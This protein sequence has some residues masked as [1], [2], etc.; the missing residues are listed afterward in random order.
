[1]RDTVCSTAEYSLNWQ[2]QAEGK[3]KS[4]ACPEVVLGCGMKKELFLDQCVE[5]TAYS[6]NEL[7]ENN[8]LPAE[9]ELGQLP[10]GQ[11]RLLTISAM[12]FLNE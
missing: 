3:K 9:S 5:V 10:R 7:L 12:E 1:M 11:S 4:L 6:F 2:P 8:K